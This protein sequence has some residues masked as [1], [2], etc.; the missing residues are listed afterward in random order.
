MRNSMGLIRTH[1]TF[2]SRHISFIDSIK[3]GFLLWGTFASKYDY[4]YVQNDKK[5]HDKFRYFCHLTQAP[6][7]PSVSASP[8]CR[9]SPAARSRSSPSSRRRRRSA[10]HTCEEL[11]RRGPRLLGAAAR[12]WR[13]GRA[14]V[15]IYKNEKLKIDFSFLPN[16]HSTQ[17]LSRVHSTHIRILPHQ[18]TPPSRPSVRAC[19][20]CRPSPAARCYYRPSTRSR[21]RS[22][23]HTCGR[24]PRRGPRLLGTL[25][26]ERGAFVL[27]LYAYI[28]IIC[29]CFKPLLFAIHKFIP[30]KFLS[31][32]TAQQNLDLRQ[33]HTRLS[34][35]C[36]NIM[37]LRRCN[38]Q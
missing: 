14:S 21:R 29:A 1:L 6:S 36:V 32:S 15:Y 3:A 19:R 34:G 31:N 28:R 27:G 4:G 20:S 16:R 35:K 10:G 17:T 37:L 30:V 9:P 23:G 12:A 13:N 11:P 5:S 38:L 22:A 33:I 26:D 7:P 24:I 8:S 25:S 18:P 2:A